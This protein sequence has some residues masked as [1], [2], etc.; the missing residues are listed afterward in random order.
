MYAPTDPNK[1]PWH[2]WKCEKCGRWCPATDNICLCGAFK[3]RPRH[4]SSWI[5][6]GPQLPMRRDEFPMPN[7]F[8]RHDSGP[9]ANRVIT[10]G[11]DA[12]SRHDAPPPGW[13]TL[14]S[15]DFPKRSAVTVTPSRRL[16]IES[17]LNEEDATFEYNYPTVHDRVFDQDAIVGASTSFS[18]HSRTATANEPG[19]SIGLP[20]Q[21]NSIQHATTSEANDA[22]E[23]WHTATYQRNPFNGSSEDTSPSTPTRR[24]SY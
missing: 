4:S 22:Y 12:P 19:R 11:Y 14:P 20:F 6:H 16:R 18:T 17:L 5:Q 8:L 23:A 2:A 9:I 1:E 15:K 21:D 7:N 24:K 10:G 3:P 13:D